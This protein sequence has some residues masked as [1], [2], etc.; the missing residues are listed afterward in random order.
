MKKSLCIASVLLGF[1]VGCA[2]RSTRPAEP[3]P[4]AVPTAG[5]GFTLNPP[6]FGV[7]FR[8]GTTE[9]IS[10]DRGVAWC[11][12]V[13]PADYFLKLD[14]P[15]GYEPDAG[16]IYSINGSSCRNSDGDLSWP[17]CEIKITLTR[18]KPV[19][20]PAVGR[21]TPNGEL[22]QLNGS[23]WQWR[24]STD[25]MLLRDYLDG[26][27]ISGVL[28]ERYE[29][30][31]NLVRVLGMAH[32]IPINAGQRAF[33]V[34]NYP[35]YFEQLHK[36]TDYVATFGL[37]VEFTALADAQL[38]MPKAADQDAFLFRVLAA[39]PETAFL[40]LCNEPFKNGC[41]VAR[42]MSNLP[43]TDTV[44]AS[45]A[46]EFTKQAAVPGRYLTVHESRDQEWPRKSRLDEWYEQVQ[47]PVVWDEPIGAD[48]TAQP[49]R[50]SNIVE[51]FYDLCAG[52]ALHGAGL[53]FHSTDGLLSRIWGSSQ[54]ASAVA[55][56]DAMTA[57]PID[58]P[59]WHYTRGGLADN[60]IQHDDATALRTFCQVSGSRAV[61]QAVRPSP[62]WT[63][64]AVNG[65]KISK[66]E[67]PGNRLVFLER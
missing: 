57:V 1:A 67:G 28:T 11:A 45:G 15:E 2:I 60:P 26:K 65:W 21:V 20:A 44:V 33:D 19:I 56:F 18:T 66:Q 43:R 25:F 63:A 37:R 32:Y 22:F 31:A 24:G 50:R 52:A 7:I 10:D 4:P 58:A 40:E 35:N 41:D 9:C 48:E 23:I 47:V 62:A 27:D 55:C 53:T 46:Y 39:L 42:L 29:A 5:V 30:G 12:P 38:L 34:S 14:L 17:N 61:C 64:E 13:A 51:D 6:V 16:G 36:F 8:L 59:L 49:G 3:V 54:K